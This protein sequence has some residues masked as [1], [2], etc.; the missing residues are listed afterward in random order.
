MINYVRAHIYITYKHTWYIYITHPLYFKGDFYKG[1]YNVKMQ[2]ISPNKNK[3]NEGSALSKRNTGNVP[4]TK[5]TLADSQGILQTGIG[6]VTIILV[7]IVPSHWKY[8]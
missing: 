6:S 2:N 8:Q 1:N 3:N 5:D 4:F 7:K